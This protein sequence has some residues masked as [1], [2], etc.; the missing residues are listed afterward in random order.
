MA[1]IPE[2]EIERLKSEIS[3]ER[4]VE[5][6]GVK[7]SGTGADLSGCCPFHEDR[8]A[9]PGRH[10]GEEP[11]ALPGRVPGGRDGDR[12]GDA[13]GGRQLPARG[14]AAARRG[15]SIAAASVKARAREAVDAAEARAASRER[16]RTTELLRQVV[17]LLPRDA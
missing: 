6:R 16:E 14:G 7:L 10:A 2:A 9:E 12:L 15:A 11:L 1:R 17:E 5:A 13:G 8:D 3:L 4:L